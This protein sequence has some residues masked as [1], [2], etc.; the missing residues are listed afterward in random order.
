MIISNTVDVNCGCQLECINILHL[1]FETNST[2]T[3]YI[4]FF[5]I[6]KGHPFIFL[7][8]YVNP[9]QDSISAWNNKHIL[10]AGEIHA[11]PIKLI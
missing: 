3:C 2:H 7:A 9:L 6:V 10:S 8:L 11:N 4:K 1:V 5:E